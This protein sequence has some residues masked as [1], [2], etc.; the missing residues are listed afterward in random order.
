MKPRSAAKFYFLLF[1]GI[2][3]VTCA[4]AQGVIVPTICEIRPCR[5]VPRPIP[6]PKVLPVK[7]IKIDKATLVDQSLKPKKICLYMDL[8]FLRPTS[9]MW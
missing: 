4:N 1:V 5:P 9:N 6:I 2:L 7:S 8:R 3:P